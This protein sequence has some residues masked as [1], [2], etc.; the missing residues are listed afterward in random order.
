[1][2]RSK[3]PVSTWGPG[4]VTATVPGVMVALDSDPANERPATW[5][6]A[7]VTVGDDV[8]CQVYGNLLVIHGKGL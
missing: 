8:W 1:M 5:V 6:L 4:V 3:G 7:A 2:P